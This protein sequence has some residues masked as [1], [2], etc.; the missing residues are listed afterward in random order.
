MYKSVVN[1]EKNL[2]ISAIVKNNTKT[3]KV[4]LIL[5]IERYT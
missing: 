3:T 2:K 4:R 1:D 5:A